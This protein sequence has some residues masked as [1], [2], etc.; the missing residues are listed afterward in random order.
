MN[1]SDQDVNIFKEDA[2]LTL[3]EIDSDN[4]IYRKGYS[5]LYEIQI[6]SFGIM[7]SSFCPVEDESLFG[8]W[9]YQDDCNSVTFIRLTYIS[10]P[11]EINK[12]GNQQSHIKYEYLDSEY[13]VIFSTV[14]GVIE[15]YK[16]IWLHSPRFYLLQLS[17]INNW[18]CVVFPL[19]LNKEW[20]YSFKYGQ[21]FRSNNL[22][23]WDDVLTIKTN[24]KVEEVFEKNYKGKR[25]S[26]YRISANGVSELGPVHTE[27]IF[28]HDF[29]FLE[30][31][32]KSTLINNLTLTLK[33]IP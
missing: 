30:I 13:K 4:I 24:Y 15:N 33:A 16:N 22:P 27:Y 18:P 10:N 32:H 6:D 8:S 25:T 20:T 19:E 9:K 1:H 28:S 17:Y 31:K 12:L 3:S 14:T 5:I 2:R 11:T 29:G 23:E 7:R 26:A 21:G